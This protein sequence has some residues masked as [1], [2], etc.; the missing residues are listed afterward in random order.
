MKNARYRNG[1]G[2]FFISAIGT[3]RKNL[4]YVLR[5]AIKGVSDGLPRALDA[6]RAGGIYVERSVCRAESR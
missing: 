3:S 4:R 2:R 5:R 1:S 6:R